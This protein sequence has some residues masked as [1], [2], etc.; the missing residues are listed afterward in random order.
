MAA[1][2]LRRIVATAPFKGLV[3]L[4]ASHVFRFVPLIGSHHHATLYI[5]P[6]PPTCRDTIKRS[7]PETACSTIAVHR[8]TIEP[9]SVTRQCGTLE[10]ARQDRACLCSPEAADG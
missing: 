9:S 5:A 6:I 7:S 2:S 3:R 10:S 1:A 8:A 4:H